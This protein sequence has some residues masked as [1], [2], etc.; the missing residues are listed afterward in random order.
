ME[1]V[2]TKTSDRLSEAALALM[3]AAREAT[4]EAPGYK[5]GPNVAEASSLAV[6]ALFLA[7]RW[8]DAAHGSQVSLPREETLARIRGLGM[9]VGCAIGSIESA[10]ARTTATGAFLTCLFEFIDR[11][12]GFFARRGKS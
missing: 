12:V 6:Q 2:E 8:T 10:H 1:V 5:P 9:G 3:D 11:R 7:D 4:K